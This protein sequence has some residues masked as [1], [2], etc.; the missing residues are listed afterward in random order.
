MPTID[1]EADEAL[2][3]VRRMMGLQPA[4]QAMYDANSQMARPGA[5]GSLRAHNAAIAAGGQGGYSPAMTGAAGRYGLSSRLLPGGTIQPLDPSRPQLW[6]GPAGAPLPQIARDQYGG[7][8]PQAQAQREATAELL[9]GTKRPERFYNAQTWYQNELDKVRDAIGRP[10]GF[11]PG[12]EDRPGV[13]TEIAKRRMISDYAA[14]PRGTTMIGRR[15]SVTPEEALG[16]AQSRSGERRE[17]VAENRERLAKMTPMER[18]QDSVNKKI[19]G[20]GGADDLSPLEIMM[21]GGN[22]DAA[23]VQSDRQVAREQLGLDKEEMHLK[24]MQGDLDSLRERRLGEAD[25]IKQRYLDEQ[26]DARTQDMLSA[27]RGGTASGQMAPLPDRLA[28]TTPAKNLFEMSKLTL[29]SDRLGPS[30]R[31][32]L[33]EEAGNYF[34]PETSLLERENARKRFSAAMRARGIP[35]EEI[36]FIIEEFAGRTPEEE[37]ERR[38]LPPLNTMRIPLGF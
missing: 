11:V 36:D 33:I 21:I 2:K 29:F 34:K 6:G 24:V 38:S 8:I 16:I 20:G 26:I 14:Q 32:F 5:L 12:L 17:R 27:M 22:P 10:E 1:Y 18:L 15:G 7:A 31:A 25:P 30:R 37:T 28:A 23:K 35:Q 19:Q 3:K 4:I 9:L 13:A